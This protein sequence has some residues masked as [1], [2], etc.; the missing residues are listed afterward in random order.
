MK[1]NF[2]IMPQRGTAFDSKYNNRPKGNTEY[3]YPLVFETAD[4]DLPCSEA[5]REALQKVVDRNVY[6]YAYLTDGNGDLFNN[7]VK[8][9][10]KVRQGL[11]LK[12]EHIFPTDGSLEAAKAA[13]LAFTQPGDGIIIQK[14]GYGPFESYVINSTG[15]KVVK[16]YLKC[17]E[18]GY[19]TI[20]FEDLE[21][22]VK[23]PANKMLLLRS[24]H[25]PVGRVWT[26]EELL[27]IY[28]ICQ[29]YG[30]LIV[31][32][33]VHSD[34][35]REGVEFVS[36]M[37]EVGG[38][39]VITCTGAGKTFNLAQMRPGL[40]LVMDEDLIDPYMASFGFRQ[41]NDFKM[42]AHI[43]AYTESD[44]WF[45][46]MT[47]YINGNIDVAREFIAKRLPKAKCAKPEGTYLLWIDFSGY[48]LSEEELTRRIYDKAWV[49][50]ESGA[51]F[52]ETRPGW[53]RMTMTAPRPR[54]LEGLERIAKELEP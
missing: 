27:K 19:Y 37:K 28:E 26:K 24:P 35:L 38:K 53:Q 7:A 21:E 4:M 9:W 32:D 39:G 15:R 49:I 6:G 46:Q 20:D 45:E 22:K 51:Q 10:F 33:E 34:F 52:E 23:D 18:N 31:S 40:G 2:D 29:K 3:D 11:E 13:V 36:L 5:I 17:D 44:D 41:I 50:L 1:Y 47:E 12:D 42:Y 25:N 43:A 48:G 30:K 14:P 16:N 54:I 8:R